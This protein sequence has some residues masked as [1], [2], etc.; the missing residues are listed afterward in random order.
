MG[1][2]RARAIIA[3]SLG[4]L[5]IVGL[6]MALFSN[7]WYRIEEK[8]NYEYN[9]NY[10][11]S[12]EYEYEK[13]YHLGLSEVEKE[14]RLEYVDDYDV[15]Q[16][17]KTWDYDRLESHRRAED[18]DSLFNIAL[19]VFI[20]T[21]IGLILSFGFVVLG[22]LTGFS[23][24]PG[25]VTIIVGITAFLCVIFGPVYMALAMPGAW[26]DSNWEDQLGNEF[27]GVDEDELPEGPWSSFWDS[28][29]GS[30]DGYRSTVTWDNSWG[31]NWVWFMVLGLG[32][33]MLASSLLCIGIRRIR[34][35]RYYPHYPSW[36]PVHTGGR[37]FDPL[38]NTGS[39]RG[40]VPY[41]DN[42]YGDNVRHPPIRGHSYP[43]R[44]REG[45]IPYSS[46][47]VRRG[48]PPVK[49]MKY[50]PPPD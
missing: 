50:P 6:F 48:T 2:V 24:V 43:P 5:V 23:L 46:D 34:L 45:T 35:R 39:H 7:S 31:P 12:Y 18:T 33:I 9:Y 3:A 44:H 30:G 47:R 25:W 8:G 29:S 4:V 11:Y 28:D 20:F 26:D 49:R 36:Q 27:D 37:I 19:V 13:V 21:L 14:K 16:D 32:A 17:K 40:T 38:D 15:E 41:A 10:Y 1:R 42:M 22:F